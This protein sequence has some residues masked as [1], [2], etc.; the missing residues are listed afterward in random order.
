MILSLLL[1]P[2]TDF[3]LL[4][5]GSSN[6][7]L[8]YN[9]MW[10]LVLPASPASS[11]P[12][13]PLTVR[14][15]HS[16]LPWAPQ[17]GHS[18]LTTGPLLLLIIVSPP[19]LCLYYPTYPLSSKIICLRG[20]SSNPTLAISGPRIPFSFGLNYSLTMYP[21]MLI[22]FPAFVWESWRKYNLYIFL[23]ITVS[24][25]PITVPDTKQIFNK[26]LQINI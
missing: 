18:A 5:G 23:L 17:M 21:G 19:H 26:C 7:H 8:W 1:Q 6:P 16:G 11:S 10:Y 22:W 13:A 9:T 15:L 12:Y 14:A 25:V 20:K 2:C 24:L 4:S 3:P